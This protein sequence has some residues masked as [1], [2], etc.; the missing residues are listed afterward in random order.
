MIWSYPAA[1]ETSTSSFKIAVAYQEAC[2]ADRI[3]VSEINVGSREYTFTDLDEST[4]YSVVLSALFNSASTSTV[5][6]STTTFT[7]PSGKNIMGWLQQI[8]SGA[9][10]R[11]ITPS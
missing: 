11:G 4:Q 5:T 7:V 6:R 3:T 2:D 8:L 10:K 1:A 9:A